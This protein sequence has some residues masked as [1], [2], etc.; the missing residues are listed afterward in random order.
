MVP[1]YISTPQS[2]TQEGLFETENE[3]SQIF[4]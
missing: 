4:A 1:I 3:S 2:P